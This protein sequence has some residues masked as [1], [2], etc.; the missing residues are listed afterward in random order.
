VVRAGALLGLVLLMAGAAGRPAV[1]PEPNPTSTVPR[2]ERSH[3]GIVRGPSDA[4]RIAIEFTGHEF[5]EGGE[6]I[7]DQLRRR[8]AK[9]SF[10][11]TGDFL[12]REA[13]APLVR[14]ILAEGHYLGPHSD[15]HL[16]YCGWEA[17]RPTLVA[18]DVFRRDLEDNLR[19]LE[20][21]GVRRAD[22][23][24]W[25]PPYEWYND[26]VARWSAEA[27]PLIVNFTPGTRANADYTGDRDTNFISSQA[28]IES[29]L[30]REKSDPHGLN[31]F[32]LLMHVGAGPGRSDKLYDRLGELLDAL[33][34]RGYRF[35]RVDT[36]LPNPDPPSPFSAFVLRSRL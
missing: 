28:I 13:F 7:L 27:G 1:R 33:A 25:V 4:R 32:L 3:G 23:P 36:L 24:Y 5:A 17:S 29:I 35:V 10:F 22:V 2:Q 12:R 20:R 9:A 26:E 16:L 19:E 31:G 8:G 30:A 18:R 34:A 15:K 21:F 14:R 6:V 11:F